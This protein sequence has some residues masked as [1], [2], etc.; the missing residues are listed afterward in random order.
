MLK[1]NHGSLL[2]IDP[3]TPRIQRSWPGHDG[4]CAA[5]LEIITMTRSTVCLSAPTPPWPENL[6]TSEC[7]WRDR[8]MRQWRI[9]NMTLS[10]YK[11][12]QRRALLLRSCLNTDFMD[13]CTLFGGNFT[14]NLP[15]MGFL[16][17]QTMCILHA[18]YKESGETQ[19][20]CKITVN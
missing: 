16:G 20:P 19:T 13:N 8:D 18:W 1:T 6:R 10:H 14:V 15:A 11:T 2:I 3:V 12:W 17:K 7:S 5:R 9:S 4:D